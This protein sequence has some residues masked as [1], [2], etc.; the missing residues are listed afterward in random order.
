MIIESEHE[1]PVKDGQPFDH[2]GPLAE[3]DEVPVEFSAF[4]AMHL[5]I[6]NRG[7]HNHFQE[8]LVKYL[9]TRRGN[10]H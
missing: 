8:D 5:E 10:G 4:L 3:L 2:M 6:R 1:E 9:W 7:K